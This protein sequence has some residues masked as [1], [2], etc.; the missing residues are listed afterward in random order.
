MIP[1]LYP[2]N[3]ALLALCVLIADTLTVRAAEESWEKLP[4]GIMGQLAN[5]EGVGGVK[6]AG[7]VRKPEGKGPF[8]L[9]IVL[10]GGA[11]TA[12]AVNAEG[13]TER[14]E[15]REREAVRAGNILGRAL[16]PPIPDFLA[17]GWA[18]YTIDYR[19]NPR[20]TRDPLEWDD[21][22]VA[23]KRAREFP[24]VDQKRVAI[25]GGSH[26]GHVTARMMARFKFAG[27]VVCAPAGMDLIELAKL[28]GE[29]TP[30]GANQRLV[31][32]MEQRTGQKMAEVAKDPAAFQYSSLFTEAAK[33]Q[34]PV[35]LISGRN[36]PNAP[37]AAMGVYEEK[38]RA[39][40]KEIE[41]YHPDNG[42]HGF[43]VG[44]PKPI[45]ETAEATRVT[46]EF[47]RKRFEAVR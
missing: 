4:N 8:P 41:V 17:Q 34:C 45:P 42:P 15:K 40:G 46:V 6:I 2:K 35:L 14:T 29:G 20:Y 38:L 27:A 43:Y 36:D 22:A 23:I 21:T 47:L 3:A 44:L 9:I 33:V 18:V 25:L 19:P 10:H 31:R 39:A 28:A 1:H 26:G 7:Y 5:F 12:K 16:H 37:I 32:E 11:P 13:E 24:F 30:I